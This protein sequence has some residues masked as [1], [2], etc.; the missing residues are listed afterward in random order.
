MDA[1]C[2]AVAPIF[3][4][5]QTL[6]NFAFSLFSFLGISAPD[7]EGVLNSILSCAA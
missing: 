6:I 1:I 5:V 4:V 2:S 7:V 3:D